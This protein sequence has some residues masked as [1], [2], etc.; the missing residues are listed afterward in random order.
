MRLSID[1]VASRPAA[2]FAALVT[3]VLINACDDVT[4]ADGSA[5]APT[6][7]HWTAPVIADHLGPRMPLARADVVHLPAGS[8]FGQVQLPGTLVAPEV[9]HSCNATQ[10]A[11]LTAITVAREA[12]GSCDADADCTVAFAPTRCSALDVFAVSFLGH[13]AFL[14]AVDGIEQTICDTLAPSCA[15]GQRPA[16]GEATSLCVSGQCQLRFA[17]VET[18]EDDQRPSHEGCLDCDLAEAKA[19]VALTVAKRALDACE[20]DADCVQASDDAGCGS[21]CG[22]AINAGAIGDWDEARASIHAD[23]CDGGHCPIAAAGCMPQRAVCDAG[24]CA[25]TSDDGVVAD[26]P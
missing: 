5:A 7:S 21:G 1:R 26:A 2:I 14:H 20:V 8:G 9:A 12:Y 25:L 24:R 17:D 13:D 6:A 4:L 15:A 18:C 16:W 19:H 23:Y 11:G 10:Q 3:P 22:V